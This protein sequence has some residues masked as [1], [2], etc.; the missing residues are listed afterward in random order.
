M[1]ENVIKRK[2]K[3]EREIEVEIQRL[4]S[5]TKYKLTDD[6]GRTE[7]VFL[8]NARSKEFGVEKV[9]YNYENTLEVEEGITLRSTSNHLRDNKIYSFSEGYKY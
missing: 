8:N 3:S 4:A 9:I 6:L 7:V 5:V 2:L 1:G